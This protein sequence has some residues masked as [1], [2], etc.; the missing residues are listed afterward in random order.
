MSTGGPALVKHGD[1]HLC[2]GDCTAKWATQNLISM[3]RTPRYRQV[4]L[5]DMTAVQNL[6][7]RSPHSVQWTL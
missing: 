7:L 3:E 2:V 1:K 5:A 6:L 4:T